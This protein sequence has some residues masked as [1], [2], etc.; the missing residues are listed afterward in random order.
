MRTGEQ[1]RV[2]GRL[3]GGGA[4]PGGRALRGW[5]LGRVSTHTFH[6]STVVSTLCSAHFNRSQ[7]PASHSYCPLPWP[8]ATHPH[9]LSP[10]QRNT[11]HNKFQYLFIESICT[12]EA[13]GGAGWI[14]TEDCAQC[15]R[16]AT[17]VHNRR[18]GFG[19]RLQFDAART[20]LIVARGPE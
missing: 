2:G 13:V 4:L 9:P 17:S 11:F 19:T 6:P 16:L 20:H 1:D 8:A 15:K 7:I 12:D 10:P 5:L 18:H 14:H 3:P